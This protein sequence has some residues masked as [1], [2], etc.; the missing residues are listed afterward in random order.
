MLSVIANTDSAAIEALHFFDES[1]NRNRGSQLKA[2]G[3]GLQ[4]ASQWSP[5]T[6]TRRCAPGKHGPADRNKRR[7]KLLLG[8][9]PARFGER[10]P[11]V[12]TPEAF[13][14]PPPYS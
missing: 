8:D 3:F 6:Q 14:A 5:D 7:Q 2:S 12:V 9:R 11:G 10:R 4:W 1:G 13:H